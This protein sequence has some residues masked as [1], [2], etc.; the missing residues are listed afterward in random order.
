MKLVFTNYR[1]KVLPRPAPVLSE[2]FPL[3]K[4]TGQEMKRLDMIGR[5]A[6]PIK[7]LACS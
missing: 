1:E 6:N 2:Q 7:C 5:L 3:S 4:V